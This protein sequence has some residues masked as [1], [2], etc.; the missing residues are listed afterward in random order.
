[1]NSWRESFILGSVESA[2]IAIPTASFNL[3]RNS[4]EISPI[5]MLI[6]TGYKVSNSLLR[7]LYNFSVS[8]ENIT[9]L[10]TS[11]RSSPKFQL[12][13]CSLMKLGT[14]KLEVIEC[15]GCFSGSPNDKLS[16]QSIQWSSMQ[17]II[18]NLI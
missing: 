15:M 6:S 3:T 17:S 10:T 9:F 13:I 8:L 18:I 12:G 2:V 14:S 5:G 16:F 7:I 1:M 11:G 4:W